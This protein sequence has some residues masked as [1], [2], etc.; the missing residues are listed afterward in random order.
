MTLVQRWSA[1]ELEQTGPD[2][3]E[4]LV[5]AFLLSY[6]SQNTRKG[7][8]RDLSD[9]LRWCASHGL[10]PMTVARAHVDAYARELA[11]VQGRTPA[12]VARRLSTL[13]S[14]YGYAVAENLLE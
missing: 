6:D 12:T 5:A 3:I 10:D 11:E 13:T 9:W 2:A 14:F 7:Y 1:G 8:G 4:R